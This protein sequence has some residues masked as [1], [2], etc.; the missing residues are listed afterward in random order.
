MLAAGFPET[1]PGTSIDR[2]CGSSQHGGSVPVPEI[3][4]AQRRE[5][6]LARCSAETLGDVLGDERPADLVGEDMTLS[7]PEPRRAG[8]LLGA[9]P[10][11]VLSQ[12][13]QGPLVKADPAVVLGVAS[14]ATPCTITRARLTVRKPCPKSMSSQCRPHSS[15]RRMPVVR[16]STHSGWRRS[17]VVALRKRPS[18]SGVH[19]SFFAGARRAEGRLVPP[20]PGCGRGDLRARR[21]QEPWRAPGG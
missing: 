6:G 5:R 2:Q 18:C 3:V 8:V 12:D 7:L 15:P 4:Q 11:L 20:R 16:A 9:L 17:S 14:M 10:P 1:V 13:R 21:G 19:I